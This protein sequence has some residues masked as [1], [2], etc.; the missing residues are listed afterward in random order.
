MIVLFIIF[1]SATIYCYLVAKLENTAEKRRLIL[2]AIEDYMTESDDTKKGF[3]LLVSMESFVRTLFR[4]WDWGYTRI[5]PEEY[6]ELIK[7]YFEEKQ[8][9]NT[10]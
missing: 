4:L 9:G 1:I 7:P 5:L 10:R 8:N 2:F 6:F 3:I